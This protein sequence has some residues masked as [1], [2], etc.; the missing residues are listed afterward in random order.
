MVT[1]ANSPS[2]YKSGWDVPVSPTDLSTLCPWLWHAISQVN[3]AMAQFPDPQEQGSCCLIQVQGLLLAIT[4][5]V[6]RTVKV[7]ALLPVDNKNNLLVHGPPI[8]R[9]WSHYPVLMLLFFATL[10]FLDICS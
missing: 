1:P 3:I 2:T 7:L 4:F 9:R 10:T 6:T 8:Y 5:R